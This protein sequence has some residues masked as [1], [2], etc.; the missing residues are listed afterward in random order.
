MPLLQT[1]AFASPEFRRYYAGQTISV[2]GTWMQSVAAAW[3]VLQLSHNSALALALYG[4]CQYGP[5]LVFGLFAGALV[6]RLVHRDLLL[7]TQAVSMAGA[8]VYAAL[9]MA[10]VI[11]LPIVFLMA[12]A[13]GINQALY[14]PARQ[15][16]VLGMVGRADLGSAV[17]L[18]S[19]AFNLARIIGPAVAGLVIAS[20]G[21]A[22]CFWL[23]ALSYAG[24]ILALLTIR[25][26]P[27]RARGVETTLGL[28][29]EGLDYVRRQPI[30]AALF[31]LL[32]SASVFGANFTLVLPLFTR[33]SLHANADQLGY[34]FSAQ[35]LGAFTGALT[36]TVAGR[37]L[38]EPRRI[39]LAGIFFGAVEL[40]FAIG[41]T[42]WQAVAVLLVIGWSFAV[43]SIGTNTVVQILAPDRMQ[44]RMMSVYSTIFIGTTPFG[45]VFAGVI[46]H[47][48]GPGTAVWVGG[49]L[50]AVTGVAVLISLIARDAGGTIGHRSTGPG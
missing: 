11:T 8:G 25:R 39:I 27:A 32:L 44:G 45:N 12:V 30:L 5:V 19:M 29:A 16:T 49:A 4:A 42:F 48:W 37:S 13:L 28:I 23:N 24:V 14:F 3:L 36:M 7:I 40:L 6:D 50:T 41:P 33:V 46:A 47:R 1:S 18:N 20:S 31:A 9:T 43:Y 21:V 10:H 2:V 22:A 38:L 26:R 35:G 17:A 15:A 34:L